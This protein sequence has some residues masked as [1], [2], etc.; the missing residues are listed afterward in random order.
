[1]QTAPVE[2]IDHALHIL[3]EA[4]RLIASVKKSP[5]GLHWWA[6]ELSRVDSDLHVVIANGENTQRRVSNERIGP[7]TEGRVR[8]GGRNPKPTRGRPPDPQPQPKADARES[9]V[10]SDRRSGPATC[11]FC[12]GE[13]FVEVA[14]GRYT[15]GCPHCRETQEERLQEAVLRRQWEKET[16]RESITAPSFEDWRARRGTSERTESENG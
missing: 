1:M 2:T 10:R 8:K 15:I 12:G 3:R 11:H 13:G 4:R 6:T 14:D 5:L 16:G 9:T 7:L